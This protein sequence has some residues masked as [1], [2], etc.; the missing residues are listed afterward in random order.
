M[1]DKLEREHRI[2]NMLVS[3]LVLLC[4]VYHSLTLRVLCFQDTS[5][6]LSHQVEAVG[7][8]RI[9]QSDSTSRLKA[10]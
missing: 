8:G 10:T 9:V 2:L 5:A 7:T 3:L 4:F 6:Q 1:E